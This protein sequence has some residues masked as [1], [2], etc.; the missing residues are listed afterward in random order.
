[1]L[2]RAVRKAIEDALLRGD[3]AQAHETLRA[4]LG[5]DAEDWSLAG[6]LLRDLG[7]SAGAREHFSRSLELE[8]NCAS[9][10]VGRAMLFMDVEA[11]DQ[12]LADLDR[13]LALDPAGSTYF[14]KA[15]ALDAAGRTSEAEE[16]R[17]NA[18]ARDPALFGRG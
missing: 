14:L 11:Y 10:L 9:A 3:E 13:S 2:R 12:A 18:F 5:N 1:M 8:P 7:D 17:Q 6:F 16:A 4:H 15:R